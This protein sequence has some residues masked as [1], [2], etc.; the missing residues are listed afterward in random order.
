M[1]FIETRHVNRYRSNLTQNSLNG[2]KCL[3]PVHKYNILKIFSFLCILGQFRK[4]QQISGGNEN[5]LWGVFYSCQMSKRVK[6]DP[7]SM[8]GLKYECEYVSIQPK[9]LT[10]TSGTWQFSIIC[11]SLTVKQYQYRA[12]HTQASLHFWHPIGQPLSLNLYGHDPEEL[13]VRTQIS[14]SVGSNIKR[15]SP[16]QLQDTKSV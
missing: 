15:K 9:E 11:S 4:S 2:Q 1:N 5:D 14:Q 3:A 6:F 16:C 13:Y 7:N 12:L 8:K 10:P